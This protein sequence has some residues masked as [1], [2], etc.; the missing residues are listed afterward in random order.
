MPCAG[1]DPPPPR[2]ARFPDFRAFLVQGPAHDDRKPSRW[3]DVGIFRSRADSSDRGFLH[4]RLLLN[5]VAYI[6]RLY[7][8]KSSS[9]T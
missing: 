9:S 3:L 6:L 1:E 4:G 8:L 5:G 2:V 7:P